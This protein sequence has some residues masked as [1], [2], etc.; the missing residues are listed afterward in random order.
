[1]LKDVTTAVRA[2][3]TEGRQFDIIFMDPPYDKGLEM[4]TLFCLAE[5][6]ILAKDGLIVV[7]SS[8]RTKIEAPA[9]FTI[10]KERDHKI[11]RLTFLSG[12][13]P[14]TEESR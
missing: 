12:C 13:G 8:S 5:N 10:V 1:M 7:E 9:G 2:L 6:N 3:K 4:Q 14:D 11:S